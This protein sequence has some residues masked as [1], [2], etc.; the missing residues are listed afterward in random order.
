MPR[1]S[2][3][4]GDLKNGF[5]NIHYLIENP[6][7]YFYELLTH[8]LLD[9]LVIVWNIAGIDGL[10]ERPAIAVSLKF[11]NVSHG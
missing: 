9:N 8:R 4:F 6:I 10:L 7:A 3:R 2:R 11:D 5:K 1:G